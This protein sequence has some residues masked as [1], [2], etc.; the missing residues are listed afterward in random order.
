MSQEVSYFLAGLFLQNVWALSG[1]TFPFGQ[2]EG[3]LKS[4]TIRAI[5]SDINKV[6]AVLFIILRP[7]RAVVPN[8]KREVGMGSATPFMNEGISSGTFHPP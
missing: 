3:S 2:L 6:G 8:R 7:L 4:P 1:S 5:H